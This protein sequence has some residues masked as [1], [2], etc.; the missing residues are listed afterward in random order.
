MS[1]KDKD[2]FLLR[3][4]RELED[5][6]DLLDEKMLFLFQK[7]N[8]L[9]KALDATTPEEPVRPEPVIKEELVVEEEIPLEDK[10][11]EPVLEEPVPM[12]EQTEVVEAQAVAPAIVKEYSKKVIREEP[13]PVERVFE[14]PPKEPLKIVEFVKNEENLPYFLLFAFFILLAALVYGT[15]SQIINL[16]FFTPMNAFLII[17]LTAC[18]FAILGFVWKIYL[19]RRQKKFPDKKERIQNYYVFPWSLLGIGTAGIFLSFILSQ[20]VIEGELSTIIVLPV[21]VVAALV[22][23]V[24]AILFKN[25]I[26]VGEAALSI[27]LILIVPIFTDETFLNPSYGGYLYFGFFF[28][29][30]A[31]SYVLAKLKI[32]VA[33]ALVSIVSFPVFAFIPTIYQTMHLETLLVIIPSCLVATLLLENAFDHFEVYKNRVMKTVVTIVNI[34]LPLC[35]YFFLLFIRNEAEIPSWEILISTMFLV[36]TYFLTIKKVLSSRFDEYEIRNPN[37]IEF[38]YVVLIN[39]AIFLSLVSEL[40]LG[41]LSLAST[42]VFVGLY[43]VLQIVFSILTMTWRVDREATS[44]FHSIVSMLFVEGIFIMFFTNVGNVVTINLG[45]EIV[46]SVS[47]AFLYI[48]PLINIFVLRKQEHVLSSAFSIILLGGINLFIF[49]YLPRFLAVDLTISRSICE[50]SIILVSIALGVISLLDTLEKFKFEKQKSKITTSHIHALSILTLTTSLWVFN[51]NEPLDYVIVCGIFVS[52]ALWIVTSYLRRKIEKHITEDLLGYLAVSLIFISVTGAMSN[53]AIP[54]AIFTSICAT[55]ALTIIPLL[56]KKYTLIFALLLY[57]PQIISLF[58]FPGVSTIYGVDWLLSI[59]FLIPTLSLVIKS[60]NSKEWFDRV[61][62]TVLITVMLVLTAL[63]LVGSDYEVL[64]VINSFVLIF[65]PITIYA[66]NTWFIKKISA[67]NIT[68]E[69]PIDLLILT[70]GA[71]FANIFVSTTPVNDVLIFIFIMIGSVVGPLLYAINRFIIKDTEI[72]PLIYKLVSTGFIVAIQILLI[73]SG[74]MQIISTYYYITLLLATTLVGLLIQYKE[75]FDSLTVLP[76]LISIMIIPIYTALYN[77]VISSWFTFSIFIIYLIILS[78]G[79]FG[80]EFPPIT[81]LSYFVGCLA[82]ILSIFVPSMSFFIGLPDYFPLLL[83]T[84]WMI[85]VIISIALMKRKP[86][87]NIDFF[88]TWLFVITLSTI[89]ADRILRISPSTFLT[90]ILGF[91]LTAIPACFVFIIFSSYLQYKMKYPNKGMITHIIA[92][93]ALLIFVGSFI[94]GFL[95]FP[96]TPQTAK[97]LIYI[98]FNVFTVITFIVLESLVIEYTLVKTDTPKSES[99]NIILFLPIYAFSLAISI[100]YNYYGFIPLVLGVVFYGM[101]QRHGMKT[102]SVLAAIAVATS[103]FFITPADQILSYTTFGIVSGVMTA[104]LVIGILLY[105][106]TKNEFHIVTA[107]SIALIAETIISFISPMV[108]PLQFGL[109]FNLALL[110][111]LLGVIFSVREFRII[112]SV[113]SGLILIPYLV[114]TF[115]QQEEAG[116]LALLFLVTGIIFILTSY[117]VYNRQRVKLKESLENSQE[118]K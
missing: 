24:I 10:L 29:F 88:L 81:L 14:K 55:V 25:E 62:T 2:M 78:L 67:L 41:D 1:S 8:T 28:V 52:V 98:F 38:L 84:I 93:Q 82:F 13:A 48:A 20:T 104:M 99:V 45:Y 64:T 94:F 36:V 60:I 92:V 107:V 115:I 22:T 73:T 32:T 50:L 27:V 90:D 33:P 74:A 15:I 117:M 58:A 21:A 114:I 12:R 79:W 26:L 83:F 65:Y 49:N 69:Y 17:G 111:L 102:S 97:I 4:M 116:L 89:C 113:A 16:P 43:F 23:L 72:T 108:L 56:A 68:I 54:L 59:V 87:K 106:R 46:L 76:S 80:S 96:S 3:K 110:G 112:F 100:S 9:T 18:L 101:S 42:Y 91:T 105:L 51:T 66:T 37:L 7:V 61:G 109:A 6:L 70:F 75:K 40:I 30:I 85:G 63:S 118:T 103:A 47:L 86:E 44:F 39:T 35:S 77:P 95:P 53:T 11:V 19:D 71:I 31:A 34:V 5:K 57:I